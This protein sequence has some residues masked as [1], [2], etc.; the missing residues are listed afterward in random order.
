ERLRGRGSRR[1]HPAVES[2][3]DGTDRRRVRARHGARCDAP[4]PG[5]RGARAGVVYF[6]GP[7][8]KRAGRPPL[9]TTDFTVEM[10]VSLPSKR[11]DDLY[12]RGRAERV[13]VPELVR[14]M[15]EISRAL[16]PPRDGR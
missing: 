6:R 3:I 15:L 11:Y 12:R 13:T 1:E 4:R 8:M 9:D 10:C 2:E 14:R 16:K 7:V 5:A